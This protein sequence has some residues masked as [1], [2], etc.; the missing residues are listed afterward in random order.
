MGH[1]FLAAHISRITILA[2]EL[3][4]SMNTP[5]PRFDAD[6]TQSC[7]IGI[8]RCEAQAIAVIPLFTTLKP[9]VGVEL[10][11]PLDSPPVVSALYSP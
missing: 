9:K 5:G 11:D 1:E 3:A 6:S 8:A 4:L 7:T 10:D 2:R